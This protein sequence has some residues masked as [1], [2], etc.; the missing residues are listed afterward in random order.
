MGSE[1]LLNAIVCMALNV[2][3]EGR[4]QTELGQ[5]AIAQVTMERAQ[6]QYK[7]VCTV[8]FEPAQFSWTNPLLAAPTPAAAPMP[9]R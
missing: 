4:N 8:V 3:H 9:K 2:Y 6:Q 7:N 5:V 1:I